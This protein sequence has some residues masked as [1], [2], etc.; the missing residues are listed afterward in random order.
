MEG[1]RGGQ[2]GIQ[3]RFAM[4][5]TYHTLNDVPGRYAANNF[6]TVIAKNAKLTI[7]EAK[8]FFI[9]DLNIELMALITP[10][11]EHR[12]CWLNFP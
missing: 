9:N 6:N 4:K 3:V 8:P 1:G 2:Y 12:S 11:R 5:T 10:G 7:V